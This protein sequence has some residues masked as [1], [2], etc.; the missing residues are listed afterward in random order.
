MI[1]DRI[2]RHPKAARHASSAALL[3]VGVLALY[4]WVLAPHVSYRHAVQRLGPVVG[5]VTQERERVCRML[6]EKVGQWRTLQ[7]DKAE[8]DERVF[9]G[10]QARAFVRG[11]LPVVEETGCTVLR[12]DFNPDAKTQRLDEP[13]VPVVIDVSRVNLDVLGQ[14]DQ[15]SVLLQQLRDSRPRAWIDSCQCDFSGGETGQVECNLV[16]AL[17]VLA[18]AREPA[19]E[20]SDVAARMP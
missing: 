5:Q 6:D 3:A 18:D 15:V 4:N 13:N 11:L 7:Q 8:L 20:S 14:P 19:P 10:E 12:A 16:L 9:T 2:R 17:Y 1:A